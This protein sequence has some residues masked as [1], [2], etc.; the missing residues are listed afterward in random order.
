MRESRS[1]CVLSCKYLVSR[2]RAS[3]CCDRDTHVRK[4]QAIHL[5]TIWRK[6]KHTCLRARSSR[7]LRRSTRV[8]STSSGRRRCGLGGPRFSLGAFVGSARLFFDLLLGSGGGSSSAVRARAMESDM[9]GAQ[10]GICYW[11][12]ESAPALKHSFFFASGRGRGVLSM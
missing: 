8:V 11:T 9:V 5:H 10:R 7:F 4:K 1:L 12:R 3:S 6:K 2:R